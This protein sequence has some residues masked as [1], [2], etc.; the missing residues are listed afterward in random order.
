MHS[1]LGKDYIRYTRT[2]YQNMIIIVSKV[3]QGWYTITYRKISYLRVRE[4][5]SEYL[6]Y[7]QCLFE[8]WYSHDLQIYQNTIVL[9]F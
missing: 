8:A 1:T 6:L 5:K 7:L 9:K 3:K 4:V 2:R